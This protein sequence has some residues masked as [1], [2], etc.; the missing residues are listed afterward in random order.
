MQVICSGSKAENFSSRYMAIGA[1]LSMLR[2]NQP[3]A[4][5]HLV[6]ASLNHAAGDGVH[7]IA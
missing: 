2:R 4:R 3:R 6:T 1:R 5:R 7:D